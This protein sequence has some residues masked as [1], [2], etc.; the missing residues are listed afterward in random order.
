MNEIPFIKL[1]RTVKACYIFDV[2]TTFDA[3]VQKVDVGEIWGSDQQA[4]K[5]RKP[6]IR[7]VTMDMSDGNGVTSVKQV[8]TY[9][10]P[11]RTFCQKFCCQIR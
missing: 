9:T 10:P 11:E 4:Q 6:I 7:E 5:N 1:F 8:N 2:N 3:L